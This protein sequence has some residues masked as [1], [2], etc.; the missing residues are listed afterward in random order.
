MAKAAPRQRNDRRLLRERRYCRATSAHHASFAQQGV[1]IMPGT[2]QKRLRDISE[3]VLPSLIVASEGTNPS[4]RPPGDPV[5][6]RGRLIRCRSECAP[7]TAAVADYALK[8]PLD[9]AFGTAR[10][11]A[12]SCAVSTMP[13]FHLATTLGFE[14]FHDMRRFFRSML[15]SPATSLPSPSPE[16]V[17]ARSRIRLNKRNNLRQ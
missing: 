15:R 14:G 4:L 16:V 7:C 17:T 12:S 3:P 9:I 1:R 13:V 6:L 8:Q 5:E 11:V 10:S 2:L